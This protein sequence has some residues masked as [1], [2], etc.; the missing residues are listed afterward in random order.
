MREYR[1]QRFG[2][3]LKA[4][5]VH[6]LGVCAPPRD[7]LRSSTFLPRAIKTQLSRVRSSRNAASNRRACASEA[8]ASH[9]SEETA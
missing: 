7:S 2:R 6:R 4:A 1:E 8:E 3:G 9:W 5:A